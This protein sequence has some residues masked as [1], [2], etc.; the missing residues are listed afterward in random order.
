MSNRTILYISKG[1][2]SASTRYRAMQYS[3]MFESAGWKFRHICD[4]KSFL[5]RISILREAKCSDVVVILR[6]AYNPLF[7]F[8]LRYYSK[9]LVFDFDDAIFLKSRGQVSRGRERGFVRT[10]SSCDQVWAGNSYLANKA[11]CYNKKVTIL[12]TAVDI[13]KYDKYVE[14]PINSLDIVWIGSTA[15]KKHLLTVLPALEKASESIPTLRLKII[16]DFNLETDKLDVVPVRWSETCEAKELASAHI[17]IAPL[18]D[19]SYTRGKCALKVI[20]YMASSLPVISSP[21]GVNKEIIEN[22]VT[23][24]FAEDEQE[25]V[26]AIKKLSGDNK[27]RTSM[28]NAARRRCAENFTLQTVFKKMLTVLEQGIENR[29]NVK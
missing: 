14:K 6:R 25:W 23:G 24:I 22:G 27:L 8:L 18:P 29:E 1:A 21:T 15:T 4:K 12:P 2:N 13:E 28:G 10:V 11:G 9:Y 16:A 5:N 26:N 20:Q 7:F 3:S 17:G 19:N